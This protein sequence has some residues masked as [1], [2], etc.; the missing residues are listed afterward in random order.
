MEKICI[1]CGM[2]MVNTEDFALADPTKEYCKHCAREDGSMQSYEEKVE[3]LTQ[4]VIKTQG[5]AESAARKTV[6][7]LMEKLPAW[8]DRAAVN[9]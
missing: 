6:I 4:F 2:P 8:K 3:S 5:Y 7:A 9:G 1:A